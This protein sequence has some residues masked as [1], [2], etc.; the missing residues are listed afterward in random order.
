MLT[1][2][3]WLPR[4]DL[5][6]QMANMRIWLDQHD[7]ETSGFSLANNIASLAFRVRL[8]AEAFALQFGGSVLPDPEPEEGRNGDLWETLPIVGPPL[9]WEAVK[10][11][12]AA[13][14]VVGHRVGR[15]DRHQP[16]A[17]VPAADL[18]ELLSTD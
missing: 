15:P 12:A 14:K 1:V 9:A 6:T 7:V 8:Q 4:R 16:G 2:D 17:E 10:R 18:N 13:R 5:A 3:L 11:R